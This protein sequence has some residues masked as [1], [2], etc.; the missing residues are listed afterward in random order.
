MAARLA[1]FG[2]AP[3]GKMKPAPTLW[4]SWFLLKVLP[5]VFRQALNEWVNDN[6]PR[7]GA[8][9]AFYTL[10][11]LAPVIVIAVAVAALVYG[12]EAAQGRLASE[13]QGIAGSDVARAIQELIIRAHQPRTGVI[14]TLL[15]LAILALGASSV[16][17]ELHDAMNTIW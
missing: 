5:Q 17:I 15:G 10:L 6:A 9:V 12:Q 7:L 1:G 8:S 3:G 11:S 13:I 16:F 2:W 4:P 14:A